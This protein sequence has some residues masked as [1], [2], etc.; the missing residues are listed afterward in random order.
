MAY[1]A[2]R[3]LSSTNPTAYDIIHSAADI[4]A[5]FG[6]TATSLRSDA[7]IAYEMCYNIQF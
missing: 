4:V 3:M 5:I 7:N 6:P 2:E 1:N